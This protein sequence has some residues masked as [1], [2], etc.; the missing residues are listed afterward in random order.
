M[1][2]VQVG[3]V[4]VLVHHAGVVVWVAVGLGGG[5]R[6]VGVLVVLVVGV[7][8]VVVQLAVLMVMHVMLGQMQV[9]AE[10]H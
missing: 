10:S 6:A 3:V 4:A 8:V 1:P 2:V 5:V 7:Q 9:R